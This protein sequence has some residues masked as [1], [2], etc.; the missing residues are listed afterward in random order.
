MRTRILK[1]S[2]IEVSEDF[3]GYSEPYMILQYE[4]P[5]IILS[6][7]MFKRIFQLTEKEA[8][9]SISLSHLKNKEDKLSFVKAIDNIIK[10]KETLSFELIQKKT[11]NIT[12]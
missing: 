7:P 5:P 12:S 3:R 8:L 10:R 6:G 9:H 2:F 11:E 1:K 4:S